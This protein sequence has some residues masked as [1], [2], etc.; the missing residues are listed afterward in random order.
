MTFDEMTDDQFYDFLKEKYGEQWMLV[1]LTQE[2]FD[3]LPRL[4]AEEIE[5]LLKQG[6]KDRLELEKY[7][8]YTLSSNF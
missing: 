4:S 1:S 3:R 6:H 8:I 2:E 7:F 5:D